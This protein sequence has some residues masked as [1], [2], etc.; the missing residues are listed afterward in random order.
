V[1]IPLDKGVK[2]VVSLR[3]KTNKQKINIMET[4]KNFSFYV[5]KEFVAEMIRA[6]SDFLGCDIERDIVEE[7]QEIVEEYI[8][9]LN[10]TNEAKS[11][12]D[13]FVTD[14]KNCQSQ[15]DCSV[16]A[17]MYCINNKL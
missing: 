2:N 15:Q 8:P 10:V 11:F 4:V 13:D 5:T 16:Y 14:I 3:S 9:N 12:I 17:Q 7:L 6:H 1:Y